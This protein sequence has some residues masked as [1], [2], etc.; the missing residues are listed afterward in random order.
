MF[1]T[2]QPFASFISSS[3]IKGKAKRCVL[4]ASQRERSGTTLAFTI[5]GSEIN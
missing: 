1:S 3:D 2:A 5:A 4:H